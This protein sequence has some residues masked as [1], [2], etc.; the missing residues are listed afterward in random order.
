MLEIN[1]TVYLTKPQEKRIPIEVTSSQLHKIVGKKDGFY[2]VEN[3]VTG[4]K[5]F[6]K[7]DRLIKES[8]FSDKEKLKIRKN[9]IEKILQRNRLSGAT[10]LDREDVADLEDELDKINAQLEGN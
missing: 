2:Q 7:S 9:S 1:D 8:K 4:Y 10:M 3:Q 5:M 6:V